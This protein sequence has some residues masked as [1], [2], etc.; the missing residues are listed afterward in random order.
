MSVFFFFGCGLSCWYILRS[1]IIHEISFYLTLF[2]C[3]SLPPT[4]HPDDLPPTGPFLTNSVIPWPYFISS[5]GPPVDHLLVE[6]SPLSCILRNVTVVRTAQVSFRSDGDTNFVS[7]VP[8]HT[9]PTPVSPHAPD[10]THPGT[11]VTFF[12]VWNKT[13]NT[14]RWSPKTRSPLFYTKYKSSLVGLITYVLPGLS[15]RLFL[16]SSFSILSNACS[17]YWFRPPNHCLY[18]SSPT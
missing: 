12:Q 9:A 15:S 13:H 14:L 17:N 10:L 6:S 4:S 16:Y 18:D 1:V 3:L 8:T 7:F 11:S 2:P 5:S